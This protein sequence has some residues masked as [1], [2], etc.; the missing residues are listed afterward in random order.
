MKRTVL[1]KCQLLSALSLVFA[2]EMAAAHAGPE[3]VRPAP[4]FV[5]P[6]V[7][8]GPPARIASR[9][10]DVRL[11]ATIVTFESGARLIVK[12]TRAA[13]GLV[14]VVAAFGSG[15]AGARPELVH[16][17]WSTTLF[18]LGGTGA[19]AYPDLD[20]W[21][22]SSGRAINVTMIPAVSAFQLRGEVPP[23]DLPAELHLMAAYA[24]DP[25]FRDEAK[26][27]IAAIAPMIADQID[28]DQAAAFQRR[29]QHALVGSR[30]QELPE[31]GD[32]LATTGEELPALL[33]SAFGMAADVAVVGDVSVDEAIRA[34][35]EMLAAGGRRPV[36]HPVKA[37]APPL[38]IVQ[39]NRMVDSQLGSGD[40]WLGL[41]WR[42]PDQNTAPRV[43]PAA[44]VAAALLEARLAHGAAISAGVSN[45]PT[46][47][48][49]F[50]PDLRG[51][52]FL[53]IAS[54]VPSAAAFAV[55]AEIM[56]QAQALSSGNFTDDELAKAREVVSAQHGSE[57]ESNGW[58]AAR[59]VLT[60]RDPRMGAAL[61]EADRGKAA[62]CAE[63]AGLLQRVIAG[64]AP[65]EIFG[66]QAATG[67]KS[68]E[69]I[70]R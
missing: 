31:R 30:Y 44:A 11:G 69:R 23:S 51:G 3:E 27:K 14:T 67:V 37:E 68:S 16:A 59:L 56:A 41:Y 2:A 24:R 54:L 32:L 17:L 29:V 61:R 48:A 39:S 53:G 60:L 49:V 33:R 35:A 28:G 50:V 43:E 20:Q 63:V 6:S 47:R 5:E 22:R 25:G 64:G 42:L 58:W 46:A 36:K 26:A 21:Q 62:S 70:Q 55:R 9:R 66:A 40:V 18:P 15:R 45:P 52:S 8:L 4:D 10:L 19:I 57:A 38:V 13:P 12:P 7:G 1:Q 34:M 65:I